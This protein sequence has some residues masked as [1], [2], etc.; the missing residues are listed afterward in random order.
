MAR[1]LLNKARKT[2]VQPSDERANQKI[3][4]N[5]GGEMH[6]PY[7]STLNNVSD[8]PLSWVVRGEYKERLDYDHD[9]GVYFFDRHPGIF[10]NILNYF[11]TGK[12]HCPRDVCG[13]MFQ[14]ELDFWGVDETQMEGMKIVMSLVI[15][16]I[17]FYLF[18][19]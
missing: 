17:F 19:T 13:P 1:D 11:Q 6:S 2:L 12:L 4:I 3:Y 9:S 7:I 10:S 16:D 15:G 5:V 8:C 18:L 14:E